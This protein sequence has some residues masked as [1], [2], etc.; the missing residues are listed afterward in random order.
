M[1]HIDGERIH[2]RHRYVDKASTNLK[3]IRQQMDRFRKD[4]DTYYYGVLMDS[5]ALLTLFV[6]GPRIRHGSPPRGQPGGPHHG[7]LCLDDRIAVAAPTIPFLSDYRD[8]FR[9]VDWPRSDIDA[10][11]REHPQAQWEDIYRVLSYFDIKNLAPRI[12]T[13]TIMGVGLQD[14]T[15]PPHTNFAGYNLIGAKDYGI[16]QLPGTIRRLNG[17]MS[18]GFKNI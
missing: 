4:K 3:Q 14:E 16:Y 13:P 7:R 12:K 10:Y 1:P 11:M 18:A 15:C 6:Q 8:Y 17:G 5:S 2:L 9:I